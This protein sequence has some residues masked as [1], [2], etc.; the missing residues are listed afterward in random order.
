MGETAGSSAQMDRGRDTEFCCS[1][2]CSPRPAL[3][4]KKGSCHKNVLVK[5]E[6]I[7]LFKS[8][9]TEHAT[10]QCSVHNNGQD[11]WRALQPQVPRLPGGAAPV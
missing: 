3:A 1:S 11:S 2:L 4:V 7:N 9:T 10:F 8:L 6:F 5:A